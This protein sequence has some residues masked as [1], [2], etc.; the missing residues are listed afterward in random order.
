M[1][2][3]TSLVFVIEAWL[4]I[5]DNGSATYGYEFTEI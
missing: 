3:I 4:N 5:F 2:G 1:G